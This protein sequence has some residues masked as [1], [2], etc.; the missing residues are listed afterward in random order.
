VEFICALLR[1]A[2]VVCQVTNRDLTRKVLVMGD[3]N[4]S[5]LACVRSLGR[6]GLEVHVAPFNFRAPALSSRY[7]HAIH[8]I[9]YYLDGG[10]HWL[11][12]MVELLAHEDFDLVIPCEERTLLPLFHH[13]GALEKLAV[14]AIP[15]P[16][17]FDAFFDK[18][19]TRALATSLN[20]PVAK[21]CLWWEDLN[22]S[23]LLKMLTLPLV[24]KHRRSFSWDHLYT[25]E[26]VSLLTT[27]EQLDQFL[28][29]DTKRLTPI[30]FEQV[31]HGFGVGLSV[32]CKDG[33]ILQAF[34]HHRAHE[35]M[36]SSFYRKSAPLHP[37]RMAAVEAMVRALSYTGLG[38]FEFKVSLDSDQWILLEVNA[39]PWGSLPLPVAMGVDFPLEL[40]RA[41]VAGGVSPRVP[42]PADI[43]G[44]NLIGDL[45]QVRTNLAS[46]RMSI[47]RKLA[48]LFQ[49][50]KDFWRIPF[51]REHFDVF[52]KDDRAPAKVEW[53][54]FCEDIFES[55][56]RRI[57]PS[58][59][60][61]GH[62]RLASL[63][64]TPAKL[65]VLFICQG[66]ICRSPFAAYL[67]QERLSD[68][69]ITVDSAGMLP[70][71][72]RSSPV[73]AVQ[74]A[75]RFSI[76]MAGHKS[77]F[78]DPALVDAASLIVV[79]D[80]KTKNAFLDRY[81][82]REA[83]LILLSD[84]DQNGA[85]REIDDP[86]GHSLDVFDATYRNIENYIE[87]LSKLLQR[88]KPC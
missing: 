84:A 40:Y 57:W 17:S 53:R 75:E 81:P 63:L 69:L 73:E 50:A 85:L 28:S 15:D 44:R 24:A 74:A 62:G 35:L 18:N 55:A 71:S 27:S 67:L 46:P 33:K 21:G 38:M 37:Q 87:P 49:W 20:I 77:K 19:S 61:A 25:R 45:W 39:R 8:R 22:S 52:V 82:K 88:Q 5:F 31:F 34:E 10:H 54:Q 58:P 47:F 59:P 43:Y 76:H 9:P 66:N 4:R 60:S 86:Y 11:S 32:L 16:L 7:I 6:A 72:P 26:N 30:L 36:G 14:L 79:F 65:N 42:Y 1:C 56:K 2:G 70:R 48:Y 23:N 13:K 29:Q 51:G 78:A 68:G 41:M 80:Q 83:K 3:D 12:A 64:S